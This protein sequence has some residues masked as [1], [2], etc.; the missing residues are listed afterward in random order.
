MSIKNQGIFN[1]KL[2]PFLSNNYKIDENDVESNFSND[3]DN[4]FDIKESFVNLDFLNDDVLND[5]IENNKNKQGE[6]KKYEKYNN[7]IKK[8]KKINKLKN[9]NIKKGDWLCPKCN[10]INFSFRVKC[11]ICGINK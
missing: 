3:K 8:K 10:N 7:K 4:N 9:Y 1:E 11:N 6:N 5:E 2:Y